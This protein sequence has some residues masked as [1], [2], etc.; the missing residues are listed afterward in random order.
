VLAPLPGGLESSGLEMIF[1]CRCGECAPCAADI[2]SVARVDDHPDVFSGGG[3]N[4]GNST[5]RT[6]ASRMIGTFAIVTADRRKDVAGG[7]A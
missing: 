4:D 1:D 6:C 2:L 3:D 7:A 5:A